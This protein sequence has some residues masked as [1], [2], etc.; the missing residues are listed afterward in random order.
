[1]LLNDTRAMLEAR[2]ERPSQL[3]LYTPYCRETA[4]HLQTLKNQKSFQMLLKNT[5]AILEAMLDIK[6]IQTQHA[7]LLLIATRIYALT[8]VLPETLSAAEPAR[9]CDPN[10]SG[11]ISTGTPF[12]SVT[13]IATKAAMRRFTTPKIPRVYVKDHSIR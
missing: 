1:M 12:V 4:V 11:I 7:V 2:L 8:A 10:S 6:S 3:P 13:K 5:R 9:E